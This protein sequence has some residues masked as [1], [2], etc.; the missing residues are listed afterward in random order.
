MSAWV[1]I[2]APS[3]AAAA[4]DGAR[5]TTVPPPLRHAVARARMAVVLPEPAGA[6]ASWRRAPLV[7]ISRTSATWPGFSGVRFATAS[8]SATSTAGVG[9]WWPPRRPAASTRRCSAATIRREV[10]QVERAT[11]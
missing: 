2:W 7:A 3:W 5:P 10:C 8:M 1:S 11:V 9:T 4:A 6:I